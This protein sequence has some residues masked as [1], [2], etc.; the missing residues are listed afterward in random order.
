MRRKC[1]VS[2]RKPNNEGFTLVEL[3]VAALI[4]AVILIPFMSSFV[5]AA[6]TNRRARRV[7][8]ATT[9]GQNVFEE[10]KARSV[11]EFMPAA[12]TED[13]G[14]TDAEDKEIYKLSSET[15][16]LVNGRKFKV[17]VTL[18][19]QNYTADDSTNIA[20][21]DYN[22]S[23]WAQL[24]SLSKA[25][26]AFLLMKAGD[27]LSAAQ[28]IEAQLPPDSG[29]GTDAVRGGLKRDITL[30]VSHTASKGLSVVKASVIYTFRYNGN[31]KDYTYLAMDE[32]ELYNNGT[33]LTNTLTNVFVCYTPMYNNSGK[34]SPTETVVF[35][36]EGNYPV[37]LYLVRQG[38][39]ANA[40]YSLGVE[41]VEGS[42]DVDQKDADGRRICVTPLATNLDYDELQLS[43]SQLS[44][45]GSLN[46]LILPE[47]TLKEIFDLSTEDY[48]G[49]LARGKSA[50]RIYDVTIEVYDAN[51][52]GNNE[53]LTT[54]KGTK[55]E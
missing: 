41:V 47:D 2:K 8:E 11:A 29:V 19:P 25:E 54:W 28:E 13:T 18:D 26:N 35:K 1:A 6:R 45:S 32:Q 31:G 48:K 22:S 14:K 34:S 44:E 52:G 24:S 42:R 20:Y 23:L 10:L 5:N 17:K 43:Y 39:N 3:L 49:G 21:T 12:S 53:L 9:A 51:V 37:G 30:S 38:A 55:M 33:E 36:N 46:S 16:R 15:I 50:L 7:M 4:V 40:V 27:E